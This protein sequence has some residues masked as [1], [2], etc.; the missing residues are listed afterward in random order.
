MRIAFGLEYDGSN[1]VGWQ[2]QNNGLSVQQVVEQALSQLASHPVDV[3]CAG[4]TDRG[5][6]ALG[7]VIHADVTAQRQMRAWV[8]GTNTYLPADVAILW[9]CEVGEDF[10]ARFSAVARHYRYVILNRAARPGLEARR[11]TWEHRN[12][13]LM[14][15]QQAAQYLL[16]EHDFSSYRAKACQAASPI[17]TILAIN[18]QRSGE[19]VYVDIKANGF[20][21]HMVRNIMGVLIEIGIGNKPIDWTATVLKARDRQQAAVTALPYGLYFCQ[22]DYSNY[23]FTLKKNCSRSAWLNAVGEI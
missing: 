20:L 11:V 15:M 5:V 18:V 8:L 4:R 14:A 2:K 23:D 13:D 7:Q 22:V 12:L 10:H 21:H 6:H 1:Y 17:R 19:Y 3:I 16:G 9:A